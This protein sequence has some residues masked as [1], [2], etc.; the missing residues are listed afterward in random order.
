MSGRVLLAGPP[1]GLLAPAGPPLEAAG[2]DVVQVP[3]PEDVDAFRAGPPPALLVVD[4][5]FGPR[6]GVAFCLSLRGERWG[7]GVSLMLVVPAGEQ[8]L[9]ECLVAGINDF[10]VAP[11]PQ[12]E[13]VFKAR[14]LTGIQPRREVTGLVSVRGGRPDGGTV[15]GKTLN[16]SA[17]GLL[18]E[19]ESPLAVGRSVEVVFF[20]PDGDPPASCRALVVRRASE[21][22]LF[23]PAY[24]LEYESIPDGDRRRVEAWVATQGPAGDEGKA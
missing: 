2:F 5:S 1:D 21:L 19:L 13:L 7:R 12:E 16:V 14:R 23:H 17:S 3:T 8:H 4:E 6:G 20:L 9:E 24:G 10:L 11:F 22:A 15:V 18:V